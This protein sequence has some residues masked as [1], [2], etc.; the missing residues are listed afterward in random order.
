M[1]STC[2]TP[3]KVLRE[4]LNLWEK[5]DIYFGKGLTPPPSL[6]SDVTSGTAPTPPGVASAQEEGLP[7]PPAPEAQCGDPHHHK[8]QP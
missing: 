6:G 7:L 1:R 4:Y 5:T 8:A 3:D 2:L